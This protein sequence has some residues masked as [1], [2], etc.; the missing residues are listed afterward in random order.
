[1]WGKSMTASRRSFLKSAG[2]ALAPLIPTIA[3]AQTYPD[4]P[5]TLIVPYAA[6]GTTDVMARVIAERMRV[7]LGH[8]IIIEN[9]TGAEG[10]IGAGRVAR[11]KPDGYTIELGSLSTQVLTGALYSLPYDVL[12]DFAPISPLTNIPM[13]LFGR[14]AL[15]PKDVPELVAWL[16]GNPNK[17]SAGVATA[18]L[19]L[20]GLL[21]QRETGTEFTLVPYRGVAPARQ[22]LVAGQIDLS[23]DIPD[24]LTL[25]RDGNIKVYAV[26]GD[27]RL[28]FAGDIPTFAEMGMPTVSVLSWYGFFAPRGTPK[29]VIERLNAATAEALADHIV[30]SRITDLGLQV[31][32]REQQTPETLGTLVKAG[33]EKWWPMIKNSGIKP[34]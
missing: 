29:G 13:L 16:R 24:A 22:D 33:A 5:I 31:F 32:P 20:T 21:F 7:S 23:F 15:P 3:T 18:A 8:P 10:S 11:A 30:H 2:G 28:A 12:N 9:V 4:R 14:K 25:V 34:D 19:R 1:M 6:G 27:T 26:V 17:V